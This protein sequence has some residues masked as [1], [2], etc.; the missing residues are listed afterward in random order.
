MPSSRRSPSRSSVWA[1]P[2]EMRR[3]A[4][5]SS[6]ICWTGRPDGSRFMTQLYLNSALL[7]LPRHGGEGRGEGGRDQLLPEL[8]GFRLQDESVRVGAAVELLQAGD[9]LL[10]QEVAE[11]VRQVRAHLG[12]VE[13]QLARRLA[14][15]D[16]H[17]G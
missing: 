15:Q 1:S 14:G 2:A 10:A 9:L 16:V 4:T 13:P 17:R 7:P 3:P 5:A 11:V 12:A 6:R 8:Q